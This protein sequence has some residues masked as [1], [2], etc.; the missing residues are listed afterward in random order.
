M[1]RV[2]GAA[3]RRSLL[4][5]EGPDSGS[6]IPLEGEVVL[7]REVDRAGRLSDASVSGRHARVRIAD[8]GIL[9]LEDLGSR[10]GTWRNGQRV[11]ARQALVAGD[12]I[13][14]GRTA[15]R[16]EED[17]AVAGAPAAS[18]P[19]FP[20]DLPPLPG[21]EPSF[22]PSANGRRREKGILVGAV[23]VVVVAAFAGGFGLGRSGNGSTTVAAGP[24]GPVAGT[25][26]LESN[27]TQPD[28]NAV[29]AYHY[30]PGANLQPVRL[31]EYPTGGSGSA[32][33]TDSGVLDATGQV[34]VDDRHHLLF[35][36]NQGSDTV[37]VFAVAGNGDLRPVAGSPFASGGKAPVSVGVSGDLVVVANKAQD[38]VRKLTQVP[39]SYATFRIG[40]GGSLTPT[41]H[42][43]VVAADSSPTQALIAPGGNLVFGS[44]ESGPI[45]AFRLAA[46]GSL[47][48]GPNSG[49]TPPNDLFPASLRHGNTRF[50]LGL[51]VNPNQPVLYLQLPNAGM[52]GVYRYDA[53]GRLT[54][55]TAVPH[56]GGLE[57]CWTEV[58]AAGTRLYTDNAANNTMS[59]FDISS[60][61]APRQMQV[62]T[63][64][65]NGNPWNLGFDPT[66]RHVFM[67]DTRDRQV[68][69]AP[70]Q[71][72]EIHT[73]T[74][75]P[76]GT[77]AELAPPV[78]VPVPLGTNPFGIAV[79]P[80]R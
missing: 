38:G 61:L 7:G 32:D 15:L 31:T 8:D 42:K 58:N 5:V 14:I 51:A 13:R 11:T 34:V 36:V 67:I 77:L 43:V 80:A 12:E 23:L 16:V 25:L 63:L 3:T 28:G 17:A 72:N 22:P 10:N 71:G 65:S 19:S 79:A 26:Y 40:A 52:L 48:P 76:D 55:V 59:V 47:T 21:A 37:A 53:S 54:F 2:S 75:E 68:N 35:A 62:L 66:G 64:S 57:P 74:V 24:G 56:H 49:L 41:G 1:W 44:E 33:L 27:S 39:A 70:G 29:L 78:P 4:V 73:L 46:D 69:V 30:G 60:A 6:R 9:V 18:R 45:R 50:G 20:A